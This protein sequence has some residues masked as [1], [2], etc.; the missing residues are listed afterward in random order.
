MF[1]G[2]LCL[3]PIQSLSQLAMQPASRPHKKV[4][5]QLPT[6]KLVFSVKQMFNFSVEIISQLPGLLARRPEC[7][8]PS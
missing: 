5:E 8:G 6:Y 4:I 1:D 3:Q 2:T 7:F